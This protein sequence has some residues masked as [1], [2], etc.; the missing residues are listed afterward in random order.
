M[1]TPESTY[2]LLVRNASLGWLASA[3]VARLPYSMLTLTLVLFGQELTGSFAL[4]G[5]LVAAFSLGGALGAPVVGLLAD[6]FG[7][8]RALLA[9]T[10]AAAVSIACCTSARCEPSPIAR[11]TLP[12]TS[13]S[14]AAARGSPSG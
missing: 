3:F 8:R 7:R 13:G 11:P 14:S 6:R 5:L 2:S 12:V 10:A 9:M 1:S 4:A